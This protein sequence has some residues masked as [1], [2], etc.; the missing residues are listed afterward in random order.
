MTPE[1]ARHRWV[2]KAQE[3]SRLLNSDKARAALIGRA[4]FNLYL[5]RQMLATAD[6]DFLCG[7]I[8]DAMECV[9]LLES[10][11][12]K[13]MGAVFADPAIEV[14]LITADPSFP[15]GDV[16]G[17]LNVPDLHRLWEHRTEIDGILV[18]ELP[19]LFI[20]K[21]KHIRSLEKDE[22][23]VR[24]LTDQKP[25]VMDA[26]IEAAKEMSEEE[27]WEAL[28][29]LHALH[30]RGESEERDGGKDARRACKAT[31]RKAIDMGE[32][33][34]AERSL[35]V[36]SGKRV[37]KKG[38]LLLLAHMETYAVPNVKGCDLG[39]ALSVSLGETFLLE[40][41]QV[42]YA[43]RVPEGSRRLSSPSE[44]EESILNGDVIVVRL[45]QE[46]LEAIIAK[47]TKQE[48]RRQ[49]GPSSC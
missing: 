17:L 13:R 30:L 3:I 43:E 32:R 15:Y 39:R 23:S 10:S 4:A 14:D 49:K 20:D 21:L 37:R 19:A 1:E 44:V 2:K 12:Y 29:A 35:A 22:E 33:S 18:I 28:S 42:I 34:P 9:R 6:L 7:S 24:K 25:E 41:I 26:V 48:D 47:P 46:Q 5:G 31:P 36:S 27:A 8:P 40:P 11:G 16:G 45:P 38:L